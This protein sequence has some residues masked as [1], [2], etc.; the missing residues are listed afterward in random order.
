M[1]VCGARGV[2]SS[3]CFLVILCFHTLSYTFEL[4]VRA[5]RKEECGVRM[6]GMDSCLGR[7]H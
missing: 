1:V 2:L 6:A 3:A 7:P 4:L 5:R